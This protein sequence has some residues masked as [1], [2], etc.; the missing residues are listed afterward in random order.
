MDIKSMN[1]L[2]G[3]ITQIEAHDGVH[4][5][6][7]ESAGESLVMMSLALDADI[8]VGEHASFHFHAATLSL[9]GEV[10]DGS[11]EPNQLS[12]KVARVQK[13][14]L[15]SRLLLDFEGSTLEAI[16]IEKRR[17]D[18]GFEEGDDLFVMIPS[19]AI[20]LERIGYV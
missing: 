10:Q 5:V 9:S 15:L 1:S 7:F 6:H 12:V 13:G 11:S 20:S 4:L 18:L 3:T 19:S 16:M 2:R 14:H 8:V 17:K